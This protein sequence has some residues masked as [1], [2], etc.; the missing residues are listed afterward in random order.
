MEFYFP[1]LLQA[2]NG[3]IVC[4]APNIAFKFLRQIALGGG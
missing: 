3:K 4:D 1:Q 2:V